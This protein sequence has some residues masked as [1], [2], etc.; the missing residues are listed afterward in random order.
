MS[1]ATTT[2]KR[3]NANTQAGLEST[4][5]ETTAVAEKIT[6]RAGEALNSA[7]S[8]VRDAASEA[9]RAAEDGYREAAERVGAAYESAAETAEQGY[10]AA[11]ASAQS[12]AREI[13]TQTRR[14]SARVS[15]F[16]SENPLMVGVIGFAGG[17]LIGALLPR[18]GRDDDDPAD[19]PRN[20]SAKRGQS[21]RPA[22]KAARGAG[23]DEN[24]E[25]RSD[26]PAG[27]GG[28]SGRVQS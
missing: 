17:L 24:I 20:G 26:A 1:K 3:G 10:R 12:A 8:T 25:W 2:S 28:G 22:A 5:A 4:V 23:A 19:E 18:G 7:S 6:E 11:R 13:G 9:R 27:H 16:A 15:N 21:R 14:A